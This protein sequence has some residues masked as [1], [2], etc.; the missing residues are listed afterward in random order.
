MI[1]IMML[2]LL[3]FQIVR[4]TINATWLRRHPT[5]SVYYV[6]VRGIRE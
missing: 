1:M 6:M 2:I 5:Y 3:L 4:F